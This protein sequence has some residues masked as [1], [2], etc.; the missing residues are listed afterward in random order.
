MT[1]TPDQTIDCIDCGEKAHLLSYPP[2]DGRW[3][4]GDLVTYRCSGCGDRWDLLIPDDEDPE[5][6]L[7]G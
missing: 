1:M 3:M 6:Q 2:E 5:G 7:E 4:P